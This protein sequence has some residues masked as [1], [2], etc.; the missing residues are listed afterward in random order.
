MSRLLKV[1]LGLVAVLVMLALGAYGYLR[2]SLPQVKGRLE[3][4]LN[5]P[6]DIIRDEYGVPHIYAQSPEDAYFALGVVHA[7]DRLWQMEF[8]RRVGAGRLSEV[9]GE[10]TLD[11]DRFLRTLGVYHY[12]EATVA[13]LEPETLAVLE[14]YVAGINSYLETRTGALPPEFL[15]LRF[16]PESWSVADVLVWGKMMAWDLSGN[17]NDELLRSRLASVL[18]PEQISELWPP[19]PGDAPVT[20]PDL[21]ALYEGLPLDELWAN[22]P[23][24]EPPLI[25]FEQLGIERR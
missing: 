20:L 8:Q 9:L 17:W 21:S 12:A 13:N 15:V 23:K 18:A 24:P 5:A 25:G 11:T 16:E 6:T 4:P 3:L 1:G 2:S 19:Y 14:N 22:S 10:A 7:Q